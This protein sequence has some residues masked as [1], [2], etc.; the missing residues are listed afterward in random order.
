M[1][2]AKRYLL[3]T[4]KLPEFAAWVCH[5]VGHDIALSIKQFGSDSAGLTHGVEEDHLY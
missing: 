2:A 4:R 3:T 1:T 5:F